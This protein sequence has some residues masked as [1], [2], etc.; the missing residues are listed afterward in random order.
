MMRRYAVTRPEMPEDRATV[1]VDATH[2][3]MAKRLAFVELY[4][5]PDMYIVSPLPAIDPNLPRLVWK[6]SGE[7]RR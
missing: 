7:I 2:R 4:G 5:D 6:D 1:L 3:E